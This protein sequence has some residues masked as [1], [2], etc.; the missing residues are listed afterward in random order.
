M[1]KFFKYMYSAFAGF[2][3]GAIGSGGGTLLMP[4]L[5]KYLD[6]E[7]DAHRGIVMFI[8]PLSV[9]SASVYNVDINVATGT[10]VSLGACF[11]GIIGFFISNKFSVKTLKLIF[12]FLILFSGIRMFI[13]L[14]F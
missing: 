4:F 14:N 11:G 10:L 12:G 1:K 5:Y 13:W 3:N 6:N 7:R 2:V 9:I 8:L